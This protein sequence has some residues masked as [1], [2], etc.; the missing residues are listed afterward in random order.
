MDI[1]PGMA[2]EYAFCRHIIPLTRENE[3]LLYGLLLV[4]PH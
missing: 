1:V 3:A 2:F 4:N